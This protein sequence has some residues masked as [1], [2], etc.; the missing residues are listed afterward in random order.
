MPDGNHLVAIDTLLAVLITFLASG[1]VSQMRMKHGIHGPATVG[2]P[3][4]ERAFRAHL[5]TVENM[6]LYIPLLWMAA[7]F[8]GGQLPFWVGLVWIVGRGLYIIGYATNDTR[9]RGP[10]ALLS[11]ISR[12]G[13]AVLAVLGLLGIQLI[14]QT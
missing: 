2:H 9:K 6:I 7:F 14:P 13:L 8:Y 1:R 4:F 12:A 11:Y 3:D 5:N 10:G